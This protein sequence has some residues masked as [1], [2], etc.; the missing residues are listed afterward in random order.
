[1]ANKIEL[2]DPS[3]TIH[4]GS[5]YMVSDDLVIPF[6][7]RPGHNDQIIILFHGAIN[8]TT[9]KIPKFQPFIANT[10]GAHQISVADPILGLSDSL[11]TAWYAGARTLPLQQVL[12]KALRKIFDHLGIDRRI[13][14]GGSS[15]GF[16]ALF[17]A[18][19]D[20]GSVCITVN[21]QINIKRYIPKV[22]SEYIRSAWPGTESIESLEEAVTVDVGQLYAK[23]FSS[24]VIYL[25]ST[26][27][28]RHL[29][30]Q[31]P[32]FLYAGCANI[33][34]FILNVDYWGVPDHSNSVPLR[35]YSPWV[36]AALASPSTK[37]QDILNTYHTLQSQEPAVLIPSRVA[38][39][40]QYASSDL[41]MA[42]LLKKHHARETWEDPE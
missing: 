11:A 5:N 23:K 14:V 18:W 25:Q 26:G 16:A 30:S 36:R 7:Y 19:S 32:E 37:K 38:T 29:S 20:P 15:G 9:R 4:P 33:N 21:P 12:P 13:Y 6:D 17:Y 8:R 41:A 3:I 10:G 28:K 31:L 35:G 1:M 40:P 42:A 39:G 34:R 27:D 24:T 22:V 2:G